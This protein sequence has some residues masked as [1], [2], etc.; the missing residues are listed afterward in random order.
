LNRLWVR[1]TLAFALVVLVA[2]TAIG[3]LADLTAGQA[4][5]QYLSYA[6]IARFSNLTDLLTQYYETYGNWDGVD[7]VLQQVRIVSSSM[8]PPVMGRY[9]GTLAWRDEQVQIILADGASGPLPR[10]SRPASR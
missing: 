8:P 6:D 1:L 5:R 2:V 3:L 9:P 7:N 4:F 10:R